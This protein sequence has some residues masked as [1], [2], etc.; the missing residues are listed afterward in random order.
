[1]A[2]CVWQVCKLTRTVLLEQVTLAF[3][4][5]I[6][7]LNEQ[8]HIRPGSLKR[9]SEISMTCRNYCRLYK[10]PYVRGYVALGQ[11][12]LAAPDLTIR[13][14]LCSR[15]P[16]SLSMPN[17]SFR[18]QRELSMGLHLQQ[19]HQNRIVIGH[20]CQA[21]SRPVWVKLGS[22]HAGKKWQNNSIITKELHCW[23]YSII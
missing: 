8:F 15:L 14:A 11:K 6:L 23:Y 9:W 1:M 19:I 2:K 20:S 5:A 22:F 12:H 7:Q 17:L 21:R 10:H 18:G 13:Y 16:I 3:K 4:A